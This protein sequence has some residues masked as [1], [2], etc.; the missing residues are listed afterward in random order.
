MV[1]KRRRGLP[2]S[3]SQLTPPLWV[4]ADAD[5]PPTTAKLVAEPHASRVF[6]KRA[7]LRHR[8]VEHLGHSC[9]LCGMPSKPC[10]CP[11]FAIRCPLHGTALY[12]GRSLGVREVHVEQEGAAWAGGGTEH[13]GVERSEAVPRI[14][15]GDGVSSGTAAAVFAPFRLHGSGVRDERERELLLPTRRETW[16]YSFVQVLSVG[17]ER[18]AFAAR[19]VGLPAS[20]WT[21]LLFFPRRPSLLHVGFVA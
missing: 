13:P 4:V 6:P 17:L 12:Q 19:C 2:L 21:A 20:C 10:L 1:P 16:Y 11:C 5:R 3:T 8:D 14:R 15:G 18:F 9:V 7:H